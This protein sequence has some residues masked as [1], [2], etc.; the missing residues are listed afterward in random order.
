MSERQIDRQTVLKQKEITKQT[1][2][3][4]KKKHAH[5]YKHFYIADKL[6]VPA[7]TCKQTFA[8]ANK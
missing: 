8:L 7:D 5:V 4:N 6:P 3:Q 2:N 1:Y